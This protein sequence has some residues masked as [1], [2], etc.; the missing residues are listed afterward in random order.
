MEH[1]YNTNGLNIRG[2]LVPVGYISQLFG[3]N[4]LETLVDK[5]R[6]IAATFHSIPGIQYSIGRTMLYLYT[7]KKDPITQELRH[8]RGDHNHILKRIGKSM[9]E[10]HN[11][12]EF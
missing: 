7:P 2:Q 9:R 3:S 11:Q 4:N 10:G 5:L 1:L 6:S 12:F 8:D